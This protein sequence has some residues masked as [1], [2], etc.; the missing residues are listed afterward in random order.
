MKDT[1]KRDLKMKRN[2]L[3]IILVSL[4]GLY[5]CAQLSPA[6]QKKLDSVQSS[7]KQE[8]YQN[9]ARQELWQVGQWSLY[10]TS[11]IARDGI[12][13]LFDSSLN[14]GFVQILVAATEGDS[15]WLELRRVADGQEQHIAALIAEQ[16][17]DGDIKYKIKQLKFDDNKEVRQFSETE[18]QEGAGEEQL[19]EINLWLNFI[20]HSAYKGLYRNVELAAGQFFHVREVPITMSL[21]LGQMSG[22]V[23]YHNA[24]PV[25]PVVKFELKTSTTEWSTVTEAA[26]LVDFGSL[27][28]KSY[29]SYE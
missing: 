6:T 17:T 14:T 2:L 18:L 19:A 22:Y 23:W 27:G 26:E 29:F 5:S 24:V 16:L 8:H 21:R 10:K 20:L 9:S 25:F 12:F 11:S 4:S 1:Q 3:I 7:Q 28:Q 13:Y 15:F